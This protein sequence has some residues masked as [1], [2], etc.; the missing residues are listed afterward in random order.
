MK[1]TCSKGHPMDVPENLAGKKVRCLVCKEIITVPLAPTHSPKPVKAEPVLAEVEDE[2]HEAEADPYALDERPTSKKRRRLK[3]HY[4][5]TLIVLPFFVLIAAAA[6]IGLLAT[7]AEMTKPPPA[8]LWVL[9]PLLFALGSYYMT[10][11]MIDWPWLYD[12]PLLSI[13]VSGWRY[14][15]LSYMIRGA[16]AAISAFAC[17]LFPAF[18]GAWPHSFT[19]EQR[20]VFDEVIAIHG[21]DKVVFVEITN[22]PHDG[23]EVPIEKHLFFKLGKLVPKCADTLRES[24][25]SGNMN[26]AWFVVAIVDSPEAFAARVDFGEVTSVNTGQRFIQIKGDPDKIR[27]LPTPPDIP[28]DPFGQL[29]PKDGGKPTPPIPKPQNDGK[30]VFLSDLPESDYKPGPAHWTFGKN[31]KLGKRSNPNADIVVN[32]ATYPKGLSMHPPENDFTRVSYRLEQRYKTFAGAVA[33]SEDEFFAPGPVRFE[34]LGD[35]KSLWQSPTIRQKRVVE[36]FSIDVG[37]VKLLELR[38][39]AETSNITGSHA[40]WLDP[41]VTK[42]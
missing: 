31:G 12:T 32:G 15:R 11:A 33:I 23:P 4:P 28:R 1:L 17:A 8:P 16:V 30:S 38:V 18:T 9:T 21:R 25:G 6:G 27:A 14:D 41:F 10:T 42:K 34:L 36:N 19:E 39:H 3:R 20:R 5:S 24:R 26:S 2:T 40:V 37:N 29:K 13:C 35:G 7:L 22:V